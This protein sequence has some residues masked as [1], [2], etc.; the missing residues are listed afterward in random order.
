MMYTMHHS[1]QLP[2]KRE[3]GRKGVCVCVLTC[4]FCLTTI[5][6]SV[7]IPS[8]A[9]TCTLKCV[10]THNI[11]ITSPIHYHICIQIEVHLLRT[12][13]LTNLSAGQFKVNY[14]YSHSLG[15]REGRK[16]AQG[17]LYIKTVQDVSWGGLMQKRKSFWHQCSCQILLAPMLIHL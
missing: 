12:L 10:H 15:C 6:C 13:I 8:H 14:I 11:I 7:S 5:K 4:S 3:G 17:L 9:W 2:R 1:Q 16:N